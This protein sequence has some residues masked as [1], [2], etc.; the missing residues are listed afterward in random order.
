MLVQAKGFSR[1]A[2]DAV[3]GH[4]SAESARRYGQTQPRMTYM[5]GQNKQTEIRVGPFSAALS[6][7]AKIGRLA[8]T[9]ARL[10]RLFTDR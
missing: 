6:G 5:I 7:S 3:A 9:L 8:Q 4:G 1:E 2:L 10:E